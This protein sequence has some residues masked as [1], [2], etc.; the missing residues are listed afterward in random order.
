MGLSGA[1]GEQAEMQ[2]IMNGGE[3]WM[4]RMSALLKAKEDAAAL[5]DRAQ[6]AGDILEKQRELTNY[7]D[8]AAKALADARIRASEL[9][10]D[11][12]EKVKSASDE[13]KRLFD[14]AK[15][16]ADKI[17]ADAQARASDIILNASDKH[18]YAE[19]MAKAVDAKMVELQGRLDAN[20]AVYDNLQAKIADADAAKEKYAQL[21]D[22]LKAA[23]AAASDN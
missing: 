18:S 23:L 6:I 14:E 21:Y 11:A 8:E 22:K 15:G 1:S 5:I 16:K 7:R 2:S 19:Q 17:V 20:Q 13:A 10:A 4:A 9:I 12:T 3:N